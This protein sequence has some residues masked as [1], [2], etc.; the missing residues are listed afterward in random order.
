MGLP[1][2]ELLSSECTA[3]NSEIEAGKCLRATWASGEAAVFLCSERGSCSSVL[4]N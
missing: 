4:L 3:Q 2:A 1:Q